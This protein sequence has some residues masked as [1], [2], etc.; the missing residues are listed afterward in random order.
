MRQLRRS[1]SAA[2][3][4]ERFPSD[5]YVGFHSY[6][7]HTALR[8]ASEL[9]PPAKRVLD[10]GV[11]PLTT[12]LHEQLQVPVDTLGFTRDAENETGGRN[13]R[14]D[15]NDSID[16]SHWRRDLPPYDLIVFCEVIEHLYTSPAHVLRFLQSLLAVNGTLLLQTPNAAAIG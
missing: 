2:A 6:R 1:P 8:A 9:S 4:R 5:T 15:L 7:F 12:M 14:F 3:I 10:I 11:S 13:Y 16:E